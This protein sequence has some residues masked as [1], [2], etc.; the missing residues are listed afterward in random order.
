MLD[1]LSD[2]QPLV[3]LAGRTWLA[4]SIN[5]VER[6]LD[7]LLLVLL[8]PTTARSNNVYQTTYD[9]RRILYIL[10]ILRDI[11]ECDFRLFMQ[12]VTE[13]PI[14]KDI[15]TLNQKQVVSMLGETSSDSDFLNIPIESYI[16]LLVVTALRFI[17]GRVM[18]GSSSEFASLNSVVQTTSAE[19]LQYFMLKIT[20]PSKAV[21]LA[22]L[23]QEPILQNLAQSVSTSNLVLQVQLLGLLR[24]IV[25]LYARNGNGIVITGAPEAS[26]GQNLSQNGTIVPSPSSP[27]ISSVNPVDTISASPM[28][29][30]TIVVGLLQQSSKNIRVYWLEFLT[31]CLPYFMSHLQAMI[32]PIV[33][34]ICD[35]LTSFENAHNSISSKDVILL[36]K[37]L[38]MVFR[39]CAPNSA[40]FEKLDEQSNASKSGVPGRFLVDFVKERVFFST[41][42]GPAEQNPQILARQEL[43]KVLPNVLLALVKVWGQPRASGASVVTSKNPFT[44][45]TSNDEL[46]NK[47]TIQDQILKIIDPFMR[48]YPTQ[49]LSGIL[50][51]WSQ[52]SADPREKSRQRK[53]VLIE[54]LNTSN[55]TTHET[56]LHAAA[57]IV[58]A[59]NLSKAKA[60]LAPP[61]K[62]VDPDPL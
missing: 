26:P 15:Q 51:L 48:N 24:S 44:L 21:S 19:F 56:M 13:K 60:A 12:H 53:A 32:T 62:E 11:I 50:H 23:I 17:Q 25:Q 20:I 35:I 5:K 1:A 59:L 55:S 52:S 46:H 14:S 36:L 39:L 7:P 49:L 28:F 27:L 16:D 9:A 10:R 31:T 37:S 58:T 29:L 3:R 2:D 43:F 6:I 42:S 30:Q 22:A 61:Q 57:E 47:Y 41:E 45:P 54:M 38:S 40:V 34:C 18:S 8:D 33:N 4:D